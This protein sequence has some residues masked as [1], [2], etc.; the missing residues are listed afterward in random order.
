MQKRKR[1]HFKYE[2]SET[3]RTET[4][5]TTQYGKLTRRQLTKAIQEWPYLVALAKLNGYVT[6]KQ[7]GG[8]RDCYLAKSIHGTGICLKAR[9][10]LTMERE[11]DIQEI[12]PKEYV[13][14]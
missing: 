4:I 7:L 10:T 1:P 13:A 14:P 6:R 5:T 9:H 8:Y 2:A 3:Y 11:W 12:A